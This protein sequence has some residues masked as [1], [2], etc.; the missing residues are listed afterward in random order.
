MTTTLA[1][2]TFSRVEHFASVASTNDVVRGWLAGGT[3]EVCV[4][5]ADQQTAGRGRNGRAWVAPPG[6]SLLASLG[7]RPTWLPPAD[8]WR[9]A[10]LV[11]MAMS[12]AAEDHA[13][14]AEG[15]IRL[16]WPNDLVIVSGGPDALL[17][18]DLTADEARER[19]SGPIALQKLAGILGETDG[20]GTDDP[21]VVIGIGLNADW[22]DAAVPAE[23]ATS[24]TTLRAASGGRPIDREALLEAFL[25]RMETRVSA[26]RAGRFDVAGWT[27][28]QVT[29]GHLVSLASLDGEVQHL[30]A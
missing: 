1:P 12:D 9:L 4:A 18:G 14:L 30:C 28:R 8:S 26:L 16:K 27:D 20:L 29:T 11:A 25:G 17:V 10:A 24:M 3:P 15:T 19:Q 5:V 22:D 7:F 23:L 21:R 13:G 2:E 6:S